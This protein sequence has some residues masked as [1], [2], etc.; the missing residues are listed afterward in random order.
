MLDP[1]EVARQLRL[2]EDSRWEF[3]QV[4][5]AGDRPTRPRQREFAD[6]LAAF[7]NSNGGV[8][9]CGVMD[10]GTVQGLSRPQL[11]ALERLV[12][13]ACTDAIKP[14]IDVATHRLEAGDKPVLAVRVERGYALH[15]SPGGSYRRVGSSKR[16][17]TTDERLRLSERRSRALSLR[18]DKQPVPGTGFRTLDEPLW[19]PLLSAEG[20]LDPETALEKLALLAPDDGGAMRATVAGVLL[21][22]AAPHEWLPNACVTA[23]LYRG[24]DRASGQLDAQVIVGP[25]PRQVADAMT[26]AVRSMRVG[27]HKSPAR[28]DLP[29]Y[30]EQALFEA[31]VNAVA[32]RDYSIAGSRIRLS[33][34]ADR[35][36]VNSPGGLPNNLTID[37]MAARQ[38]TRN[39]AIASLLGRV[40]VADIPGSSQRR[41][42]MER[43]GDGVPVIVR[44]TQAL[45]GQPPTYVLRDESDL[46]LT[47]PAAATEPSPAVVTVTVRHGDRPLAGA[48]V[49]ALF[50]NAT[51]RQGTTDEQGEAALDLYATHLP[52]TVFV[53][54]RRYRA[55]SEHG[56]VPANG[57]L[58]VSLE[59]SP[60]GG[61]VLFPEATGALPGLLGRLN[62]IRDRHDRTYLY[63][64]DIA[65]NAGEA[66]PVHFRFGEEMRLTDAEGADMAVRIRDI[67]GRSALV[68]YRRLDTSALR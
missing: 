11:D 51:Y 22:T 61:A 4:E 49:L 66:Q 65:I 33:M 41:F 29:Q 35:L 24:S 8:M 48:A 60:G 23:T 50:P 31:L 12:V 21:C 2:G 47:L 43:R 1:Q 62:P 15:D 40:P 67:V 3:K 38:A 37:G 63:A 46:F 45:C 6:E 59:P 34:F 26:F 57:G 55:H 25:L 32:H 52:M 9:L 56:W 14:A 18:F 27:A 17:M 53:A 20:R 5:F 39:E 7:A 42:F 36:E 30:S 16:R 64:S 44:E 54:A 13:E 68:E 58:A 10:D 28:T 19:K